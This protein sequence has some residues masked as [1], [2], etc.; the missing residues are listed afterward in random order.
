M[1]E[2]NRPPGVDERISIL[3]DQCARPFKTKRGLKLFVHTKHLNIF[4]FKCSV[5]PEPNIM[6]TGPCHVYPLTPHFYMVKLGFT[7][8][9]IFSYFSLKHR[10]WVLIRTA[11][12][13]RFRRVPTIYVLS[14]NTKN[15]TIFHLKIIIFIAVKFCSILHG[16]VCVMM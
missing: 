1:T 8:V 13:R 9:Y 5:C 11:S 7:G 15:I 3:G 14:K 2:G 10:L 6:I 4:R 16:R 12:L